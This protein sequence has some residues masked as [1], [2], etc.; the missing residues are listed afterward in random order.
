MTGCDIG[1]RREAGGVNVWRR[2]CKWKV[3]RGRREE[4]VNVKVKVNGT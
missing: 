4:F 3:E 1:W 2:S